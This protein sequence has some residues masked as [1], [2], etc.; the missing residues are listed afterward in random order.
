MTA[1]QTPAND[2]APLRPS[3]KL[4]RWGWA[5]FDWA[6]QPFFTVV[7][8][9]IYAP[10]FASH[11]IGDPV[12]GQAAWAHL[13][14]VAGFTI[15]ILSPVLGA[16]ADAGG[17]RKG[18]LLVFQAI[19]ALGCALLWW[20]VP[21]TANGV[22]I[23]M[24][25]IVLATIGAEFSIVFN[26]ALLPGLVPYSHIGRWSG[27]GW[28]MGYSG[29]IVAL[30]AVIV[31]SRPEMAGIA[32]PEGQALFG[33]DRATFAPERFTGP[34]SAVWLLIFVLPMFLF[35]PDTPASGLDRFAAAR[36]GVARLWHTVKALPRYR[37]PTLFLVAY[38]IYNDGL[39]AIIAL[40]G[41]Y[42]AGTFGWGTTELGIFGILL[43]IVGAGG[44]FA[45]GWLD[46]RIG[47]KAT[48]Q[49]A[50]VL[51]SIA[52][53]GIVSITKTSALYF[54]DLPPVT[55]GGGLFASPQ[56]QIF[57]V[58]ALLVGLSMGPMQAASRTMMSRLAP[59]GME[60]EFFGLFALS[61]RATTWLAPAVIGVATLWFDSQR[62][63]G[64]VVMVF[65]LVGFALLLGVRE[66][67]G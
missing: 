67:R 54:L 11:L 63:S 37:N 1:V 46:D 2:S 3:T 26:N 42:A 7:T 47:S 35:T 56:E 15:A 60:G 12:R 5:M 44:A 25:A 16:M 57:F 48:I 51:A 36:A 66:R 31:I 55:P 22:E 39:A 49:I 30:L 45:G 50:I 40:G 33:L 27:I 18:F 29:G 19:T 8:T 52:A 53:V 34:L 13:M 64:F 59:A 4:G 62:P 65:M 38:M 23:A 21:G 9:F 43:T 41:I 14:T 32:T 24:L 17:R 28:G 6:N 10:F 58:F 20:G 61:G